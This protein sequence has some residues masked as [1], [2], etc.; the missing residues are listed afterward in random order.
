MTSA[1]WNRRELLTTVTITVAGLL[2]ARVRPAAAQQVKW[3][4]APRRQS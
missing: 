4:A 1:S 3:S 2:A